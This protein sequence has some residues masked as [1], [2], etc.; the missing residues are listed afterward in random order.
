MARAILVLLT[1]IPLAFVAAFSTVAVVATGQ[2]NPMVNSEQY[3]HLR[4]IA[5][6]LFFAFS[7][8]VGYVMIKCI[9]ADLDR[10]S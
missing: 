1:G 6:L 5:L 9:D 7:G 3:L 8:I 2:I 10:R 4:G